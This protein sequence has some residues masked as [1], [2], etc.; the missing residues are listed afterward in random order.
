MENQ[1]LGWDLASSR[2]QSV[3]VSSH[4]IVLDALLVQLSKVRP[5]EVDEPVRELEHE[6][7]I[8]VLVSFRIELS[9][10]V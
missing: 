6:S 9:A 1:S 7:G 5:P 10:V 8:R 3:R 4:E 2:M